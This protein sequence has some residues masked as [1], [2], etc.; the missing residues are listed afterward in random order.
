MEQP[1]KVW[2]KYAWEG[3]FQ[4]LESG[5][6]LRIN[7]WSYVANPAG[8]FMCAY[9]HSYPIAEK[10]EM[11]LQFEEQ[12]LCFK[13]CYEGDSSQRSQVRTEHHNKL[14]SFANDRGFSELEK[15]D[16][17]GAGTWM[18][19]AIVKPE[20]LFGAGIIDLNTIIQKLIKYQDLIIKSCIILSKSKGNL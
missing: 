1:V 16:R 2:N 5:H 6:G 13:I 18:T 15:P 8:G 14:M 10:T 12:K 9:W 19:I 4:E 20:N 11:Y 3:F 7:S 17:F